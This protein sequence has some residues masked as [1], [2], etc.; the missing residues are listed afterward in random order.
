M[1]F[2]LILRKASF[3]GYKFISNLARGASQGLPGHSICV[4]FKL[5]K[6]NVHIDEKIVTGLKISHGFV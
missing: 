4:S 6:F 3:F 1:F 5:A 2:V